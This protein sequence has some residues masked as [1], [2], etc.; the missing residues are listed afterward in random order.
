[1]FFIC[2]ATF[3]IVKCL[4]YPALKQ[5]DVKH[6]KQVK[7][8]IVIIILLMLLPSTYF[9]F[10]LYKQQKFKQ[11]ADSFIKKELIANGSIIIF[12]RINYTATPKTIELKKSYS[13]NEI[14]LLKRN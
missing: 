2:I 14:R 12:K 4:K 1:M 8:G 3:S 13:E 6:Q 10:S 9:A 5:I 11:L 7:Y